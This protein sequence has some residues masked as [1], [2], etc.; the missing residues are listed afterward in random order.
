MEQALLDA[1][2]SHSDEH[3]ALL[4]RFQSQVVCKLGVLSGGMQAGQAQM[5]SALDEA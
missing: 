2:I 3:K 4:Q 1:G 5:R